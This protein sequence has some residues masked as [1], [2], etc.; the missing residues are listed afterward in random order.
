MAW[1]ELTAPPARPVSF[2]VAKQHMRLNGHDEQAYV[3]LLIDAATKVVESQTRRALIARSFR[4]HLDRFPDG[5]EIELPV[6][7]VQSLASVKYTDGLGVLT[8]WADANYALDQR[9]LVGRVVLADGVSWPTG[10]LVAPNAVEVDFTAGYGTTEAS[11]PQ[12]L[13]AAILF[14][15]AHWYENRE[16]VNAGSVNEV[17]KTFDYALGGYKIVSVV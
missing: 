7:P 10:L 12:P 15:V 14:L 11:V 13:R 4:L 8:T 3:E 16:A 9:S 1:R 17:P 6:A 2:D 5:R